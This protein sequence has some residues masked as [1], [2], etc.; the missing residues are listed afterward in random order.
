M[1]RQYG[2]YQFILGAYV[3]KMTENVFFEMVPPVIVLKV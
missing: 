3:I 1:L 2:S